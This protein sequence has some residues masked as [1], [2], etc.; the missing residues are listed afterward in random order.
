MTCQKKDKLK[1]YSF[2]WYIAYFSRE[3]VFLISYFNEAV[4]LFYQ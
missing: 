1:S 3:N 4:T 2:G